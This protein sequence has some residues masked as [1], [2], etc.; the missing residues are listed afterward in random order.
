MIADAVDIRTTYHSHLISTQSN[1]PRA[2]PK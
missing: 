2:V 1:K